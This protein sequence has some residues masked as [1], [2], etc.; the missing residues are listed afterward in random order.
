MPFLP[1]ALTKPAISPILQR[2]SVTGFIDNAKKE[3]Y[4]WSRF[5]ERA[6]RVVFAA[7]EVAARHNENTVLTEHLL[8]GLIREPESVGSQLLLR[9][10]IQLDK[11][12]AELERQTIRGD[13]RGLGVEQLSPRGQKAIKLAYEEAG[14][15]QDNY[16]GTEHLL[17][18]LIREGEGLAGRILTKMGVS[19][20]TAR[21]AVKKIR[22][23][24][25]QSADL[26]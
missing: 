1:K 25:Y 21:A 13:G 2:I 23:A 14:L 20:E 3:T 6:R 11:L 17:L 16:I 9:L 24:T 4:M 15:L 5:T 18:G 7:Q 10:G 26:Q 22:A 19:L 12:R 8:L